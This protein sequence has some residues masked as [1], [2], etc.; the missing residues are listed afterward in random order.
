ME[1][2]KR[3]PRLLEVARGGSQD[4]RI[5]NDMVR[6]NGVY[7]PAYTGVGS[8]KQDMFPVELDMAVALCCLIWFLRWCL[9]VCDLRAWKLRTWMDSRF[10]E[11]NMASSTAIE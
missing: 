9:F 5:T 10:E 7:G 1:E 2:G 11:L 4:A 3:R 8:A 6:E